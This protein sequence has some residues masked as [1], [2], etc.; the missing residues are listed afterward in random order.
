MEWTLHP[1]ICQKLWALWGVPRV[2]AFATFLNARLPLYFSPVPD[3]RALGVDA[4][5]QDWRNQFLYLFP[6][7]KTLGKVLR[8]FRQSQGAH[9]ILI[10][11]CWPQQAWFPELLELLVAE[12]RLLPPWKDLLR[13]SLDQVECLHVGT[14]RLHAWRLSNISLEREKFHRTL[15]TCLPHATGPLLSNYMK[16]SGGSLAIGVGGGGYIH[17]IPLY[18][19]Y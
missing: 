3:Q 17:S 15:Q 16:I 14:M 9:A 6:P 10:A 11:P 2:D 19:D 5:L 4:F 7:T 8:K 18:Q 1:Q 12:P 13:S